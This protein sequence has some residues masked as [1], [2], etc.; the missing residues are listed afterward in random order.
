[1]HWDLLRD[2]FDEISGIP[3][4][5]YRWLKNGN[6][7]AKGKER[8]GVIH[9]NGWM[10]AKTMPDRVWNVLDDV[11]TVTVA[12]GA[13]LIF[14]GEDP[15]ELSSLAFNATSSATASGSIEGFALSDAGILSVSG[16][17]R[18]AQSVT[19]PVAFAD[20]VGVRNLSRWQLKV[21]GQASDRYAVSVDENGIHLK[22][23]GFVLIFR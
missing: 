15:P 19:L 2:E 21:D 17:D 9:T 7:F 6:A 13:R 1:V 12:N 5:D 23:K 16:I 20:V 14:E 3:E 18:R 10:L 11:G 22:K 4:T 8:V